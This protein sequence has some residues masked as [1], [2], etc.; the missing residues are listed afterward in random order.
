MFVSTLIGPNQPFFL[1]I[2]NKDFIKRLKKVYKK[3]QVSKKSTKIQK[4]NPPPL[5]IRENTTLKL[6]NVKKANSYP[7]FDFI[8]HNFNRFL[9]NEYTKTG[10]IVNYGHPHIPCLNYNK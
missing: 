7:E 3:L 1:G 8:P 10:C 5:L 4:E 9:N 2:R 6:F